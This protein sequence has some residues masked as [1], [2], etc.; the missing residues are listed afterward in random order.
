MI[1][2]RAF[3]ETNLRYIDSDNRQANNQILDLMLVS[4]S[5]AS[6]H[7]IVGTMLSETAL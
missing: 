1:F 3:H 4:K 7:E 5:F 2:Q 6:I